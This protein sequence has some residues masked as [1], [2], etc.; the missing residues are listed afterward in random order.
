MLFIGDAG[1]MG[2]QIS[3]VDFK[4]IRIAAQRS[5]NF[6]IISN[7]HFILELRTKGPQDEGRFKPDTVFCLVIHCKRSEKFQKQLVIQLESM[8][9]GL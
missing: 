2:R 9:S 3:V 4:C 8:A 6:E 1:P 5:A 7:Q